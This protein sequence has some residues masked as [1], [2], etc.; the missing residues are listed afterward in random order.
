[1]ICRVGGGL[2]KMVGSVVCGNFIDVI[3]I[4]V[5]TVWTVLGVGVS[6]VNC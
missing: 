1:M 5:S 4:V 6:F 2:L 3:M